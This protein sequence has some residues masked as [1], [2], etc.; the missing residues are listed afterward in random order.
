MDRA[1]V[2][3][4]DHRLD[5]RTGLGAIEMIEGFKMRDEV[6]TALGWRGGDDQLALLP[7]IVAP[8][9][10]GLFCVA[11]SNWARRSRSHLLLANLVERRI[12][13]QLRLRFQCR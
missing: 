1:V 4:D 11:R 8:L 2:E 9:S 5:L 13:R 6:G 12:A 10:R 3:H 7:V